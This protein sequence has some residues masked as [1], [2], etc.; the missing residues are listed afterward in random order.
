MKLNIGSGKTTRPGY[1]SWDIIDGHSAYP[2][3]LPDAS[4][5]AIYASHILEHFGH[6]EVLPVLR[7]WVRVLVP[8]GLLQVAV[9]NFDQVIVEYQN[10]NRDMVEMWL[11]GGQTN[12]YDQHRSLWSPAKLRRAFELVGL[13]NIQPWTSN[14]TDCAALP[15][16]LNLQA[17]TPKTAAEP[18]PKKIRPRGESLDAS[19]HAELVDMARG[20][21][22]VWTT[23]RYALSATFDSVYRA[24]PPLGISLLRS[25]GVFWDQCIERILDQAIAAGATGI[26][27]LDYDSVFEP[28]DLH[29]MLELYHANPTAG[30]ICP[31]QWARSVDKP[32]YQRLDESGKQSWPDVQEMASADLVAVSTAHFGLSMLRPAAL[33][34][35]PRPWFHHVPGP[36]GSW[37]HG[38]RDADIAFWLA[39]GRAGWPVTIAPSVVIGHIEEVVTWPT[40]DL[41]ASHQYMFDYADVGKPQTCFRQSQPGAP[42]PDIA[43]VQAAVNRLQSNPQ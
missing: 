18:D 33:A 32:L 35:I 13:E 34:A 29:R 15:I 4:V 2:L 9:P 40:H 42:A 11:M 24:L 14:L 12:Q 41:T 36:A 43:A 10:G 31:M 26:L 21:V 37:V 23:P 8:G 17:T 20:I 27:T 39:M 7:E 5:D 16:S 22:A 6:R 1:T 28:A 3:D 30:A 25:A 38:K 19:R